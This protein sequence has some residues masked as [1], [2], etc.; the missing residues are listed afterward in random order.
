VV[1]VVR[2]ARPLQRL[3]PRQ[4]INPS[5]LDPRGGVV[6]HVEEQVLQRRK[7]SRL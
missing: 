7:R 1:R 3:A 4:L 2:A 6:H 5:R